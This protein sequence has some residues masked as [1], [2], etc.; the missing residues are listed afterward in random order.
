M[1][2]QKNSPLISLIVCTYNRDKFLDDCLA[3]ISEQSLNKEH[4]EVILVNN[5]ST[6]G[7]A[8]II[9]KYEDRNYPNWRFFVEKQ[10]GL[11][12]A[13]NRGM[14][15]ATAEFLTYVDDDAILPADFLHRQFDLL[16]AHPDWDGLG[17]KILAKFEGEKPDWFNRYTA[18][19]FF[20]HYDRGESPFPYKLGDFPFGC[21][22][23]L[24]KRLAES[25]GGFD[26]NL[27]RI[28]KGGLGGEEKKIFSQVISKGARVWYRP[29]LWVHHQTDIYR[30]Q[31]PYLKKISIGLGRTHSLIFCGEE[32]SSW[33]CQKA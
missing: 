16:T 19:T 28:G 14:A 12:Y 30:T 3:S 23:C 9:K 11:S 20:S 5:N 27:G 32:S 2:E 7:T 4:F 33:S 15:E 8:D 29:E 24:R 10:Q 17:G 31:E 6:D 26:I 13:R 21:N 18:P 22:M 25:A 1:P